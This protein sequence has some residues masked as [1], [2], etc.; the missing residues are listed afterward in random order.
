MEV[1]VLDQSKNEVG[2]IELNEKIFSVE[3]NNHIVF[4]SLINEQANKRQGTHFTKNR[5]E[6]VGSGKKPWRQKGTGRARSGTRKSP[7]WK[8]G[9]VCFG[10][11]P[12]DY[13]YKMPKKMKRKAYKSVLSKRLKENVISFV[14]L[15]DFQEG[16]TKIA[17]SFLK[18]L[19]FDSKRTVIIFKDENPML[20]RAFNNIPNVETLSH[21]RLNIKDLYYAERIV[22]ADEA[23]KEI[24][25]FFEK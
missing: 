14:K 10:P 20:K 18:D 24:N 13:S 8:G 11:K 16:K 23:A 1:A 15:P 2:K 12:R 19:G 21:K 4:E 7:I 17:Y 22:I 3:Y 6:V 9:G 5:S 25:D